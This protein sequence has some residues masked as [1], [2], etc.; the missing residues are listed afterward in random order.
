M[1][2]ILFC[3]QHIADCWLLFICIHIQS[4]VYWS[5]VAEWLIC[6]TQDK[7]V[8]SNYGFKVSTSS[9]PLPIQMWKTEVPC[10]VE[11]WG[12][13]WHK[14]A[15]ADGPMA[16]ESC[17]Y[18]GVVRHCQWCLLTGAC[19]CER[20]T[21]LLELQCLPWQFFFW[22]FLKVPHPEPGL[23]GGTTGWSRRRL[24]FVWL[25]R[26]DFLTHFWQALGYPLMG[27]CFCGPT[28]EI[29]IYIIPFITVAK[30]TNWLKNDCL[31]KKKKKK[32][33][34][35]SLGPKHSLKLCEKRWSVCIF[36]IFCL[37][38]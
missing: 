25:T 13:P 18:V 24:H 6:W 16:V 29:Y 17:H 38:W 3:V 8:G 5:W 4:S 14:C 36:F 15:H 1:F 23:A 9:L 30:Q 27:G 11:N 10:D 7:V 34:F 28:N 37:Y 12:S 26:F 33:A 31:K 21:A 32:Q 20:E 35:L 2:L 19:G 22:R